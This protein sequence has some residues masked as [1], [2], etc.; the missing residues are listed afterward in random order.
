MIKLP[1]P[2]QSAERG[3]SRHI[4][5]STATQLYELNKLKVSTKGKTTI[6]KSTSFLCTLSHSFPFRFSCN[7][8][9]T[10]T[11]WVFR[12]KRIGLRKILHM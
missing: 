5:K 8:V 10:G 12:A 7:W 4:I 1:A 3:I 6:E 2:N 11:N 9:E